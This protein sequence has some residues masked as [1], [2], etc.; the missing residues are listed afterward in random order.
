M[1]TQVPD[2]DTAR[3]AYMRDLIDID[4][5]ERLTGAAVAGEPTEIPAALLRHNWERAFKRQHTGRS[6]TA[7]G[8]LVLDSSG[9]IRKP[10]PT[11]PPHDNHAR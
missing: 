4:T 1:S 9:V 10:L 8:Y 2:L 3:D 5:F 7:G 6:T 11:T